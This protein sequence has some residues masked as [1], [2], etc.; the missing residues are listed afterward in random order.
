MYISIYKTRNEN[1]HAYGAQ[2]KNKTT[3]IN[4]TTWVENKNLNQR[5]QKC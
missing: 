2:K 3:T 4:P 1:I 5:R